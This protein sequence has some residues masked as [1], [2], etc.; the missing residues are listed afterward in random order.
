MDFL[1]CAVD[2][3]D[4]LNILAAVGSFMSDYRIDKE[5]TDELAQ[6]AS[7][8]GIS[9][10]DPD[11][12]IWVWV[13]NVEVETSRDWESGIEE[14]DGYYFGKGKWRKPTEKE[15]Q[16]FLNN[17]D[18]W[19]DLSCDCWKNDEEYR[20]EGIIRPASYCCEDCPKCQGK[21]YYLEQ[22]PQE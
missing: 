5:T 12:G 20:K 11:W 9:N 13:G 2:I 7:E 14:V 15:I 22:I 8:E 21:N 3:K 18:P 16:N 17:G 6:L 10:E 4:K 1:F 19:S